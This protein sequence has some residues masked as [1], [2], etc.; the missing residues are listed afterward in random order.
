VAKSVMSQEVVRGHVT[1]NGR[2]VSYLGLAPEATGP[3]ILL[4]HGSGVNA[5]YWVEQIRGLTGAR[6]LAIDLPGHGDSDDDTAARSVE[7]YADVAAGFIDALGVSPVIAVGH[8]LGGAVA[9]ALAARR[10]AAV[11]GL[12]LLSTCARL[13]STGH[14]AQWLLPF[15]PGSFRKMLFFMTA[16]AF[17]FAPSASAGAVGFGMQELRACRPETLAS[18]IAISR[19]MDLTARARAL[20][21]PTLVLCGSRD[22]I[23]PPALSRELH[24]LIAGSRLSVIE[25]AGHMVLMEAPGLVNGEIQSFADGIALPLR[26][27]ARVPHRPRSWVHRLLRRLGVRVR[28][29]WPLGRR[30]SPSRQRRP[31]RRLALALTTTSR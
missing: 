25:G 2:R 13:P 30:P 16:Q 20:R 4:I 31:R 12:V 7:Q 22:Q 23:T 8:S 9:L 3:L 5:R 27:P 29:D 14:S 28:I 26:V 17:L 21:V 1:V 19:S 10:P 18:D 24:G 15:L 6:V 11:R